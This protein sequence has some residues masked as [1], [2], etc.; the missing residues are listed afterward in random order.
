M[1]ARDIMTHP[2]ITFR[3]DT[4]VR[5]AAAVLSDKQITA[6][7]V[8]D[9]QDELV[10]IVSEADLIAG[11]FGHDPRSHLGQD[12]AQ[13]QEDA[14]D[15]VGEVMTTTVVAQSASADAADLAEAMVCWD[16]R[17]IPIVEGSAVVGIVSRRDLLR[18]LIRDDDVIAAEVSQRVTAYTGGRADWQVTVTD[19]QVDLHGEVDDDAE[20]RVLLVLASTVPGVS[21][22]ALHRR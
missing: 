6:A 19:G 14:P 16:V 20:E 3:P 2:V 10:G 8:L 9:S 13:P 12:M 21:H 22:V 18:T 11:R 15:T 17:S 1:Q 5:Q 7:P 4:A